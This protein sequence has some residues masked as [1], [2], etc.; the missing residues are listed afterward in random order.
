[1]PRTQ[2]RDRKEKKQEGSC[3]EVSSRPFNIEDHVEELEDV[4][5]HLDQRYSEQEETHRPDTEEERVVVA[6]DWEDAKNATETQGGEKEVQHLQ[7]PQRSQQKDE[8]PSHIP[9]G[10]WLAQAR[11]RL[12]RRRDNKVLGGGWHLQRAVL[13]MKDMFFDCIQT[14]KEP[15]SIGNS[16][17]LYWPSGLSISNLLGKVLQLF[18]V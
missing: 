3:K 5:R 8:S 4:I 2:T 1:M 10:M 6:N 7:G 16:W 18:Y 12:L 13:D 14:H 9:R 11:A 15:E 17:F